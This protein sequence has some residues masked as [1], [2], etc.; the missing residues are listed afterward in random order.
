MDFLIYVVVA[1]IAFWIGWH[2]R[3]IIFLANISE[4]PDRVIKMLEQIK[5]LNSEEDSELGSLSSSTDG[6]ELSIERVGNMLYAYIKDTNQFV[7]QAPDLSSL[8]SEAHKR[9]P[10]QKFFG[11]ISKDNS[12]K[13][14]A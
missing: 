5:K 3:G 13:E 11:T 1:A 2:A 9:F 8:L 4:N 12:A 14:L 10:T 6:T 7:A